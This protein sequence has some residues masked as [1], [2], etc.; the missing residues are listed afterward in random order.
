MLVGLFLHFGWPARVT[1]RVTTRLT[2]LVAW[3]RALGRFSPIIWRGFTA[4]ARWRA[5]GRL[6]GDER[7][8]LDASE[9]TASV[10]NEQTQEPQA[11]QISQRQAVPAR[12]APTTPTEVE[13][14]EQGISK[15]EVVRLIQEGAELRHKLLAARR[16]SRPSGILRLPDLSEIGRLIGDWNGRVAELVDQ[17]SLPFDEQLSLSIYREPLVGPPSAKALGQIIQ[18]NATI[19]NK[20][21]SRA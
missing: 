20:I 18:N 21:I 19:L 2:P 14:R 8:K 12:A 9:A 17:S 1:R 5:A 6:L 15:D 3:I 16:Q 11:S 4:S 7:A 10:S 13:P